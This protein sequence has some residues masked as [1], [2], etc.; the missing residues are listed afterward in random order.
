MGWCASSWILALA[1]Q[2]IYAAYTP[3]HISSQLSLGSTLSSWDEPANRDATGNLIFQSLASLMQMMPNAW[4][5]NGHS[6]V[7]ANIPPGTLL[8][9]GRPNAEYPNM[10]WAA[11][12]PE[13]SLI[14]AAGENGTLFTFSTTRELNLLYFDGCSANKK[15]GVVDAQDVAIYGEVPHEEEWGGMVSEWQRIADACAWGE[16]YDIDGFVRMELDFEIIYCDFT[17]GLE[18]VSAVNMIIGG[19]VSINPPDHNSSTTMQYF[20]TEHLE[21]SSVA[22]GRPWID[23]IPPKGWKGS[24][25]GSTGWEAWHAGTWHNVFPGD[26]RV[27]VDPSSMITFFDPAL[28]SL[29]EARRPLKRE[30][31]RLLNISEADIAAVQADIND[32]LRRGF[33]SGSGVDWQGL[34]QVIQ[35]RF[36]DRLPYL[37]YLLHQPITNASEQAAD[38]RQQFIVSLIPYM[39]RT[40]IGEP[41]W[42]AETVRGCAASFTS[43]LPE[44]WFTKQERVIKDAVDEVL[45]EICRVLTVAWRA[46]FDIEEQ[47]VKTAEDFLVKCRDD[48]D[49][50]IEW[51]DWPVWLGCNPACSLDEYCFVPQHVPFPGWGSDEKDRSPQCISMDPAKRSPQ[52]S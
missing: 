48:I 44:S 38:V 51:L 42:Y 2:N 10:D 23:S 45:H 26:V 52:G 40:G 41:E 12:D 15:G 43:H 20:N 29:A 16:Q 17:E 6:I 18:L 36:S 22:L 1:V 37:R 7:R 4:Y 19:L 8:Y 5:P 32:V 33:R 25:P 27:R 24:A 46:A 13:H 49:A 3:A 11:I 31:Y 35:D 39:P 50:L 34:A 14:F 21:D 30:D 28:T 47:D 9:H